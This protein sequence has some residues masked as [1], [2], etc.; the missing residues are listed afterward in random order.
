MVTKV[1]SKFYQI[2]YDNKYCYRKQEIINFLTIVCKYNMSFVDEIHSIRKEYLLSNQPFSQCIFY[3][4]KVSFIYKK[5]KTKQTK[6]LIENTTHFKA[7]PY[8]M[9]KSLKD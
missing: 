3:I 4:D 7:T 9:S 2:E 8:R 1:N 6:R 5:N